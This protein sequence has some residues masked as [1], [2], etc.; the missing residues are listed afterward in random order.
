ML[1][2][3]NLLDLLAGLR[4]NH[5]F[6]DAQVQAALNNGNASSA[7]EMLARR[8][9]VDWVLNEIQER[10]GLEAPPEE[11]VEDTETRR[12]SADEAFDDV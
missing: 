11:K 9:V 6:S 1:N 10:H 2:T 7:S 8:R 3:D 5:H 12:P 4:K